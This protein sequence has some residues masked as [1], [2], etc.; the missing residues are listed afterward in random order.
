MPQSQRFCTG[1][2]VAGCGPAYTKPSDVYDYVL[3]LVIPG[4]NA[5]VDCAIEA[6]LCLIAKIEW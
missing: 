5:D 6:T 1:C 3:P 4:L 2:M